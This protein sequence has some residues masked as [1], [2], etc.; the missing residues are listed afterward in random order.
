MSLRAG[1]LLAVCA[2]LMAL[3]W[4]ASALAT[5]TNGRLDPAYGS[6]GLARTP[7]GVTG[8]EPEVSVAVAPDGVATVADGIDGAAARFTAA[9]AWDRKFA[10]GGRLHFEPGAPIESDPALKFFPRSIT[11]DRQGRVLVFGT[12][13]DSS[14]SAPAQGGGSVS[15]NEAVVLRVRADGSLD[16]SFA[17][18]KGFVAGSFGL[19]PQPSTGFDRAGILAGTV[20]SAGRP[21]FVAG[22]AASVGGCGGHSTERVLPRILVRLTAAGRVDRAFG[23]GDGASPIGGSSSSPGL[24]VDRRDQPV[25]AAGRR[26]GRG[27]ACGAGTAIY[28][29]GQ[30]GKR[31]TGFGSGGVRSFQTLR[32]AVVQPSGAMVLSDEYAG[33]LEV[34]RVLPDGSDDRRFGRHDLSKIRVPGRAHVRPAAVD[35]RGR[36]LLVGYRESNDAGAGLQPSAFVVGRLS[37]DGRLDRS[38]GR[39]G[40]IVTRLP[41]PLDLLYARGTLDSKGR[42]LVAGMVTKPG[43]EDGAF[44]VARYLV[45]S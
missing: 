1:R 3:G 21:L 35:S 30:D 33:V 43:H 36:V 8:A 38:F 40:W 13:V 45:G 26:G 22:Q 25:V 37:A 5:T 39:N 4:P 2:V 16:P 7:F 31:L 11:A 15:P 42:L 17:G 28:R 27:A 18:G 23:G 14:E 19:P 12:G 20:D 10:D 6:H 29:F 34:S 32:L 44:A 24:A 9:G 41:R